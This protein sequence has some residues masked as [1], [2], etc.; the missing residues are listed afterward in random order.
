MYPEGMEKP[1]IGQFRNVK[2]S[3]II[4]TGASRTGC[5]ITGIP[6][7]PI[8]N[9]SLSNI[10]ISYKGGGT[11]EN[12]QRIVPE[13]AKKYP[14][15]TMFGI[16]PAYGFYVRNARGVKFHNMDLGFE[17]RDDRPALVFD[18]VNDLEICGLDAQGSPSA[19]ALI[20]LRQVEGAFIHSCWPR[21]K[22]TTFIRVDGD[23]LNN[24]ALM[25]NDLSEVEQILE[26]GENVKKNAV[27]LG[28]NRTK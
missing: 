20:R 16:L 2:I 3:N 28:N 5:S 23:R 21:N 4:A 10:K 9:V 7:H 26:K 19:Q 8:E 17:K 14:E 11:K 1:K 15:S 22:V 27:Y 18:D 12:A 24:V 6:G 25:N 13:N